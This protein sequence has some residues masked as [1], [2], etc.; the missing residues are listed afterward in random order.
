M[1]GRIFHQ[2]HWAPLLQMQGSVSEVKLELLHRDGHAMPM[3]LNAMRREH[4]DG[5]FHELAVFVA[6]DRHKYE[7]ELLRARRQAE[8][9]LAQERAMQEA[10]S[11]AEARLRLALGSAQLYVWDVDAASG[12]RRYEDGVALLIGRP[13]PGPVAADD[14][15]SHIDPADREREAQAYAR[16][17]EG[18]DP[19]YA[20]VYHL[21]GADGRMRIVSSTGRAVH[22][23]DG[24]LA[25]FVG[26]L[27]DVTESVRQ[28]EAA[29]V[30]AAFAEQMMG[31][32]SHDLRNPLAAIRMS[33][34]LLERAPLEP[35][36]KL[37][38]GRIGRSLDRANRLIN[39]LLDFTSARIGAGIAVRKT[40]LHLHAA[41]A[42]AV[43]ELRTAF[44][45]RLIVHETRGEGVC[46]VDAD[47]LAQLLGNLVANAMTYGAPGA[48][49]TV[50]S[51]VGE[52]DCS[53]AVHNVG[54][55]VP[56]QSID[57]LF[58]PMTRGTSTPDTQRSVGLGLYIVREIARAHGG[59]VRV[60]SSAEAGTTF[61]ATL[62]RV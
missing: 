57:S 13:A 6:E 7:R 22:A 4:A 38:L 54:E 14:Y 60:E 40:P 29:E 10:L 20:C 8:E 51:T 39:D 37:A 5:T 41:V 1:G 9:L 3:V 28:K 50:V 11:L 15:A 58:D 16:T 24:S 49:V 55:P 21:N 53:L 23:A 36:P 43:A 17:V 30:R 19:H 33:V 35:K 12:A 25:R 44:E 61:S 52:R 32:V 56:A 26:V 62:P 48:T 18:A 27:Q 34:M 45:G 59:E 47:R 31:I 46:N 42:E 2:T